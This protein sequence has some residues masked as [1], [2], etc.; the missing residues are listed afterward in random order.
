MNWVTTRFIKP[1]LPPIACCAAIRCCAISPRPELIPR[2]S[3]WMGRYEKHPQ[4]QSKH[5]SQLFMEQAQSDLAPDINLGLPYNCCPRLVVHPAET[6]AAQEKFERYPKPWVFICPFSREWKNRTVPHFI[7]EQAAAK[8]K[9]T[10]F[11]LGYNSPAPSGI[12]DLHCVHLDNLIVWLSAADLLVTVDTGPM[13]IGAALGIPIVALGQASSPERHLSDQRDFITIYPKDNLVDTGPMLIGT[14]LG[15]LYPK[16]NLDCLN[17]QKNICPL[18]GKADLPP[19]QYFN[20]EEI[21]HWANWKLDQ[22]LTDK[23]SAI[24]PVFG[25]APDI[26]KR[27]LECVLPQVAKVIIT[28]ETADKVPPFAPHPKIR[29][30]VKGIPKLGYG[31][32]MNFGCRHSTGKYLLHLNDDVFLEPGAVDLMRAQMIDNVG[33]VSARLMYPDNTVYF[34][35]KRRGPNQRGWGHVNHRQH[36][37]EIKEPCEQ[38]N[39]NMA[40]AMLRRDAFYDSGCYDEDYFCYADDDDMCLRMRQSGWKL[41]LE[42][43]A[44]GIHL[45]GQSTQKVNGDRMVLVNSANATF[46]R[47]W[48]WY[49]D[50]NANRIPGVFE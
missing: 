2:T 22:T 16:D 31:K 6:V 43:R 45:E 11:W 23:V 34:C 47:K 7:W 12:V 4:R 30:A 21:A 46:T 35:G 32:N 28:A 20:P 49:L 50:L 27:C 29:V 24:I 36:H 10:K 37:W 48:S 18:P 8:I 15:I 25:T 3:I 9:G 19:C 40:A 38:E 42:P 39:L 41:V 5:F 44:S 13:H 17:C 26:I 33:M 14:A 1:T